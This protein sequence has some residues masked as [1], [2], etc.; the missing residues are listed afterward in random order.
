MLPTAKT[1]PMYIW[2]RS[3]TCVA[4]LPSCLI[5]SLRVYLSVFPSVSLF[6]SHSLC[7]FLY[8]SICIQLFM[9]LPLSIQDP[10]ASVW[11]LVS[12]VLSVFHSLCTSLPSLSLSR[13]HCITERLCLSLHLSLSSLTF[14]VSPSVSHFAYLSTSKSPT[15]SLISLGPS[16]RE[17]VCCW[18][19]LRLYDEY[20]LQ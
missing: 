4:S 5:L 11:V 19:T 8:L 2:S 6:V 7:L 9:P 15:F 10:S 17:T 1:F 13:S 12:F 14:W 16:Q 20:E 3:L 18:S